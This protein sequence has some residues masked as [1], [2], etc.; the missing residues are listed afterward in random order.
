MTSLNTFANSA[1]SVVTN[2]LSKVGNANIVSLGS[3][4]APQKTENGFDKLSQDQL[5]QIADHIRDIFRNSDFLDPPTLCVVGAQSSGKSITLNGLTGLDI[6][7]NG[8]SIVTRTPIH[9][10]LMHTISKNITIEFY[11]KDDTQKVISFFEIDSTTNA[12]VNEKIDSVRNEIMRLTELYAGT[13]KNVVDVPIDIKIKSPNVPNLSVIDLPGLTNIALTDKGQ[14]ENIKEQI[15]NMII[16]YIKNP[17]TIILSIVPSTIDVE[18]DM[19]LGLIKKYDEKFSRTIGVLTKVDMLKDSHVENYLSG[20]ISM[21]L[22]LGYGYYLVRNRSSE[23]MKTM[24]VKDGYGLENTFFDT[25]EPYK[26]SEHRS[27]MGVINL[28]NKLSEILI[29]HLRECLPIVFEEIKVADANIEQQLN[30][31]GREFPMTDGSKRSTLNILINEFQREYSDS[32]TE[33][34]SIHNTGAKIA[35]C[36]QKFSHNV[37]KLDPFSSNIY[38]NDT[39]NKI[40]RDYNGIHMHDVVISIGIIEKCFQGLEAYETENGE[41]TL[42]KIEPIM[43]LRYPFMQCIRELQCVLNDLVDLILQKDKYSRFPKLCLKIKELV[44]SQIIP[45]RYEQTCDKVNDFFMEETTY[46]WTDDHKFRYEILPEIFNKTK[47][48]IVDP[49]IMRQTLNAYFNIIKNIANHSIRKKIHLFF[50]SR[51]IKDIMSR[52]TEEILFNSDINTMLEENKEKAMKREK[53]LKM[54][55]KI[56]MAKKMINMA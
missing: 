13:S 45:C 31:I 48:G 1:A 6:L 15:E 18:S 24:N 34:G 52:L 9:L 50:T 22:Q 39:I 38:T 54:K 33:R 7:P 10:R 12:N 47:D 36:F 17:R 40:V 8:K 3:M 19:G 41:K 25:N 42:K 46:I 4:N 56:N 20:N 11:D 49:K 53:L 14:S 23:E 27:R 30:E 51:I 37:D 55:E 16:K 44:V 43:S 28:G 35:E 26:T 21:N 29:K 32:I 5:I 2:M